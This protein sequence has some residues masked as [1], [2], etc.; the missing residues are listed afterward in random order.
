MDKVNRDKEGMQ[1]G[2]FRMQ[3]QAQQFVVPEGQTDIYD[4]LEERET[5]QQKE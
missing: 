3:A 5:V 1:L 2:E 4:F